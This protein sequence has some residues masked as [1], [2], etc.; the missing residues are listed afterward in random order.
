MPP[1]SIATSLSA[2]GPPVAG[3]NYSITCSVTLAEGIVGTPSIVWINSHGQQ[4]NTTGDIILSGS[5]T[6]G[7]V[8]T[9]TLHI[10]PIRTSDE[11]TYTCMAT[12]AS[13]ALTH[14]LNSLT[15]LFVNVQHR[16]K[17]VFCLFHSLIILICCRLHDS[18]D[19]RRCTCL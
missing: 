5:M 12:L 1:D 11:G 17:S 13:L 8:T 6:S 18:G 2:V 15:T 16:K 10:D 19:D 4:L 14:P 9:Q 7:R 3:Y